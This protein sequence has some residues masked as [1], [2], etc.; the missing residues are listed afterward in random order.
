MSASQMLTNDRVFRAPT[1][2][3]PQPRRPTSGKTV[4]R[5][6]GQSQQV[7]D[8]SRDDRIRV[9]QPSR[10]PTDQT[11]AESRLPPPPLDRRG[12]ATSTSTAHHEDYRLQ[13]ADPATTG[14]SLRA[15]AM[16]IQHAMTFAGAHGV[17]GYGLS[18]VLG[19]VFRKTVYLSYL[20]HKATSH[21]CLIMPS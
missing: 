10:T 7:S 19:V 12:S 14:R 11:I 9:Q 1:L 3:M 21:I 6:R 20:Y 18:A 8:A 16:P 13:S 15:M 2:D 17:S 4:E 5:L